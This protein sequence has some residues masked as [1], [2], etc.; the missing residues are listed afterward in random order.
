MTEGSRVSTA[1]IVGMGRHY[2]QVRRVDVDTTGE[3]GEQPKD[4]N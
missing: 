2:F 1:T 4:A 3:L